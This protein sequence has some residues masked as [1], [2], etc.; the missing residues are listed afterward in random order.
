MRK[1]LELTFKELQPKLLREA[2]NQTFEAGWWVL[3]S[4]EAG[5][6]LREVPIPVDLSRY[7][8]IFFGFFRVGYRYLAWCSTIMLKIIIPVVPYP[9]VIYSA[10]SEEYLP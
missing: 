5:D 8:G 1:Y 6:M 7:G 3:W 10:I 2:Q 4:L 9:I